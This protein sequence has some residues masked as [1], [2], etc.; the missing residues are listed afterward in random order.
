MEYNTQR[1]KLKIS[2]YGRNIYKL[3]QYA[4]TIEERDKRNQVAAAIV[5]I[6][7]QNSSDAQDTE[8]YKRKYWVHLMILSDWKLDV[9]LPYDITPEETVDFKPHPISYN[10][11]K[12][13]Y[14][15]YGAIIEAM[16]KRVAD[17]PEDE[18]RTELISLI[19]HAMKRDYLLWN[20]DTVEDDLV[21][22]QL[23]SLS[24]GRIHLDENFHYNDFRDYL[25]GT[26]EERRSNGT[27]KKKKKKKKKM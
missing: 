26:D 13:R 8:D 3:I 18:E 12:P 9:D 10:Q 7:A 16:L 27:H 17:Y 22:L 14:R 5:D 2:D 25:K 15:H 21:T 23:E 20:H 6:M 4:F 1:Q 19:A 11:A 24:G